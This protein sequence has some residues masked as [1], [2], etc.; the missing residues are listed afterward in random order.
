MVRKKYFEIDKDNRQ[1]EHLIYGEINPAFGCTSS[2]RLR[3][4]FGDDIKIIIML[5]EP[6][7]RL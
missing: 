1:K 7:R 2:K 3:D 6:A 4:V 5:R